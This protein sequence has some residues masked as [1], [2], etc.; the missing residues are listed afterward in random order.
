MRLA[1]VLP[2]STQLNTPYPSISY[3]GRA[4]QDAGINVHQDDLGLRL[5]LRLFSRDGLAEVLG[6][7][8]ERA[9]EGLPEPAWEALARGQRLVETIDTVVDFLQGRDPTA[10]TPLARPGS[11]PAGP[12][13]ARAEA[14]DLDHHFGRMGKVDRARYRASL[15]LAD[16]AELVQATLDPG[17]SLAHYQHHLA[18]GPSPWAP[19]A[20]RLGR[21]TLIDGWLDALC[22]DLLAR[23]RPDVVGLSVPFPG[24]LYGALRLGQRLR[25]RG[26]YVVMGGG[27]VNTELREVDEPG[28]WGC[29][30]AL[31]Y[32]DGEGPLLAILEHLAGGPDRRHRT[33]SAQ[34]R[35]NAPAP[36]RPFNPAPD[37]GDLPLGDYLGILDSLS[38]AHRLWSEARWNKL[39]AAHGCYW[40]K[41]AFCDIQLDYIARYEPA[42][43]AA[44]VDHME[45]LVDQTGVRGFHLVDEAA[46]PRVL[47]ELAVEILARGL[48]V[49]FW[50][51]VRFEAAFTPELC[52]LLARAGMTMVTGGLE[53][54]TDHMLARM[55]KGVTVD[56]AAR[57]AHAF[58]EAGIL[59]H[60]YLMYGFPGQSAQDTV[61]SM[62]VVRQLF[63]AGVLQSAFWHRFVLTRHSGVAADPA[64]WDVHVPPLPPGTFAANDLPHVDRAGHDPDPFDAPLV[65]ALQA[66]MRGEDHGRPV[67][68]WLGSVPELGPP[69]TRPDRIAAALATAASERAWRDRSR[70]LWLG[71][72]FLEGDAFITIFGKGGARQ[73]RGPPPVLEWLAEVL[74]AA[75]PAE[76]PLR[77]AEVRDSFPG[78]WSRWGRQWARVRAAGLVAV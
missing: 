41:C 2:P 75:H 11:L 27:Y 65:A 18:A 62:E 33:R 77:W 24:T 48:D 39:T 57:A 66:W 56:Q 37:Y 5:A 52:R 64:R 72:G 68:D 6:A 31:S 49:S 25:R 55:D 10:A 60:A 45:R 21:S 12:R 15:H 1:L 36:A 20:A 35:H 7:I 32:D 22:D 26:V 54:A 51:N 29:V 13:L 30:D 50:G 63:A 23:T 59:V 28:L 71:E 61:E 34:G 67:L 73:L 4:M 9:E 40:K 76:P 53:V 44:L 38:P 42:P 74:G 69:Q 3:L 46:P 47:R 58:T 43:A 8:E 19:I 70:V 16:L 78:D 14:T 17:F